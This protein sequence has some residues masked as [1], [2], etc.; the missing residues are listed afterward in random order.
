MQETNP[1]AAAEEGN[2][3]RLR[4]LRSEKND[5]PE[6]DQVARLKVAGPVDQA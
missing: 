5:G 2:S 4:V 3:G 1:P 6:S